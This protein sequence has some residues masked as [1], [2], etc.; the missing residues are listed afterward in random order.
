MA[1]TLGE[2]FEQMSDHVTALE[3]VTACLLD[4]YLGCYDG[5]KD[6]LC[7]EAEALIPHWRERMEEWTPKGVDLPKYQP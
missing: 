1:P 3:R 2:Q 7:L 6:A 4:H 5:N